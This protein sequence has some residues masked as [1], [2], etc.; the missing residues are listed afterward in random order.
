MRLTVQHMSTIFSLFTNQLI[1]SDFSSI[2]TVFCQFFAWI[3]LGGAN[4]C[5]S[6]TYLRQANIVEEE[7]A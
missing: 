6:L 5:L 2:L 3:V 4:L 7:A 1:M